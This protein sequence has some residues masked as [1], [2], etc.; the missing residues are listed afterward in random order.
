MPPRKSTR[1]VKK[2]PV[3]SDDD[4]DAGEEVADE[5]DYRAFSFL[6][7]RGYSPRMLQTA[8]LCDCA[9]SNGRTRA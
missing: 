4:F 6:Y 3:D 2:R 9:L 1:A 8:L 7:M 5:G